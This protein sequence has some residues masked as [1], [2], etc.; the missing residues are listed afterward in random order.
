MKLIKH[1]IAAMAMAFGHHLIAAN[2]AEGTHADGNLTLLSDAALTARNLRVKFGSDAS[3]F[4]L[5][6]AEPAL[7][8]CT[9]EPAAAESAC[10]V[11]LLGAAK[12][13]LLGVG[14]A[15]INAGDYIVGDT[16]G[17]FKTLPTSAGTYYVEGKAVT[18]CGGD[19]QAFEFIPCLPYAVTVAG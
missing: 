15:A 7:G 8:I 4:A 5:A 14:S 1:L 13:T 19:G 18:A 3:H 11:A 10:N 9:D 17:R 6:G 2:I 16:Q 12:G